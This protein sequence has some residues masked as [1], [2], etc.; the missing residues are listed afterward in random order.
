MAKLAQIYP[1]LWFDRNAEEAVNFYQSIF[2]H[3]Q[4]LHR[5]YYDKGRQM[6]EGMILAIFFELCGHKM[7]ALNGGP[8]FRFSEAISMVVE[9]EDQKEI[10]YFWEKLCQEGG[11][12]VQCSWLRDKF[13]LSWQIIPTGLGAML[14]DRERAGRVMDAVLTMVKLDLTRIRQAYEG[15]E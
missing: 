4:I 2:P 5:S 14:Q 11:A 12:P 10:D 15:K 8:E 13:G 1:C 3:S 6:P 7:M 9:C